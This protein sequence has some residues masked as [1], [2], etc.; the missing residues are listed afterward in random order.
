MAVGLAWLPILTVVISFTAVI[1]TY[2]LG[3]SL[4]HVDAFFPYISDAG[5][6]YPESS[7]FSFLF[8]VVALLV[9][10]NVYIQYLLINTYC[11][12]MGISD[13]TRSVKCLRSINT[14][15]L[16]LGIVASCGVTIIA[17]F[18]VDEN[19][20]IHLLGAVLCF[21]S[22]LIFCFLH[23]WMS[24][25][26]QSETISPFLTACRVMLSVANLA[27]Y[28]MVVIYGNIL[29]WNVTEE[30]PMMR[31]RRI[32]AGCEWFFVIDLNLFFLTYTKEFSRVDLSLK[33]LFLDQT[34][35][36]WNVEL[37]NDLIQRL[38]GDISVSSERAMTGHLGCLC[39]VGGKLLRKVKSQRKPVSNV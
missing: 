15:C 17:N 25:R 35:N 30:F 7:L 37:P 33:L 32:S 23:S 4:G 1:I 5:A 8:D 36:S 6:E 27:A 12:H 2:G 20:Y 9:L 26:I 34:N 39:R 3:I 28:T 31:Y 11:S 13:R 29:R 19:I 18:P 16:L 24:Y 22:A 38:S 10:A 21:T 14:S